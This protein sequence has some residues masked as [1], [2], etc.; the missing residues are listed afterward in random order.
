MKAIVK[1]RAERGF[2]YKDVPVPRPG[3]SDV[4]IKVKAAAICGTELYAYVWNDWAARTYRNIPL[5]F[6]HECS[7]E[8]VEVGTAVRNIAVGDR[9]AVETHIPCTKCYHCRSGMQH[10]CPS[11]R[12]FGV[13]VN[14][15]FAEHALVPSVSVRKIPAALSWQDGALLEPLGVALR[16][17]TECNALGETV[18]IVG[19]GSIG[20]MAISLFKLM[21][22]RQV[23]ASDVS[24]FKLEQAQAAGADVVIDASKGNAAEAVL[25]ATDGLGVGIAVELSGSATG[26]NAAFDSLRKGGLIFII[27]QPKEPVTIDVSRNIVVKEATVKGFHGREM[28]RTWEIAESIISSKKIDL[29]RIITHRFPLSRFEEAFEVLRKGDA[30]KVMFLPEQGA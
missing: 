20:Q 18:G 27:G 30:L 3:D 11:M 1:E 29:G 26:I 28:F 9:V 19:C 23:I 4:L 22:A 13:T 6:G 7:G 25:S 21:G 24:A 5:I 10:L 16:A 2:V 15:C 8:V 12:L 17:A 14:G